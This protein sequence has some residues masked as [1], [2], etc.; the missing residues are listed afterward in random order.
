MSAQ[1]RSEPIR[2]SSTWQSPNGSALSR[3]NQHV[4]GSLQLP[5]TCLTCRRSQ[6]LGCTPALAEHDC[7]RRLEIQ[8]EVLVLSSLEPSNLPCRCRIVALHERH[9]P[10]QAAWNP[11]HRALAHA[12]PSTRPQPCRTGRAARTPSVRF[13]C[14]IQLR[15]S[16]RTISS[17]SRAAFSNWPVDM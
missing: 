1:A 11:A 17:K 6:Q 13:M 4:G 2:V 5:P 10:G 12:P 15:G 16:R 3:L 14:G 9:V 7:P 8:T